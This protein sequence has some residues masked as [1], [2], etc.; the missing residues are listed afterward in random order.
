MRETLT[1]SP[2][3]I[4]LGDGLN[5]ATPLERIAEGTVVPA[6]LFFVRSNYAPP[7]IAPGEWS[8]RVEGLV[9]RPLRIGLADLQALPHQRREVWLECAGNSRSR[10]EPKAEGNQWSDGAVSNAVFTGT[11]LRE[12]LDRAGVQPRAVELVTT[13]ADSPEFQR[14]LPLEV[15]MRPEVMLVWEMNGEPIPGPNGGPVRLLVPGWGGIASVK[16]PSLMEL[17]DRPFTGYYNRQ[18]YVQVDAEGVEHGP[19]REMPV[20]SVIAWP[21][22]GEVVP[23]GS[24]QRVFGF[25]W[26]GYAPIR[27]VEVSADDLRSW[28]PARLMRGEGPLAWT[29]WEYTW[30][31]AAPGKVTL[32]ARATDELG[33]AQPAETAWNRFGYQMNAIVRRTVEVR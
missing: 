14:G 4:S 7:N 19:V 9:E 22:E 17:I 10:F 6:P 29:R 8:L 15:A 2:D 33:H 32:A 3:L 16:W 27:G 31:P 23:I 24:S 30:T 20:K 26:S 25:A 11:P 21:T 1:K 18:R 13:G 28:Q 12:V 5:F